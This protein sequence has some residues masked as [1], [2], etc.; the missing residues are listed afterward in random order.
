MCRELVDDPTLYGMTRPHDVL[1]VTAD[2]SWTTRELV[3]GDSI[4]EQG[5]LRFASGYVLQAIKDDKWLLIDEANRADLDRI[6]GGL[7]TW[8]SGQEVTIG[9]L[10]PTKPAEVVLGWSTSPDSSAPESLDIDDHDSDD[11]LLFT[12]GTEWRLIGTYNSVDAHRVFR[13]GLALGRRF[14]Q[15]PVPPPGVAEFRRVL[16]LSVDQTWETEERKVLLDAVSAIYAAHAQSDGAAL[17]PAPFLTIPPYVRASVD[18]PGHE[19]RELIAEAYL[20]AFGTWLARQDESFL[21]KIGSALRS[22]SVL[23]SQWDWVRMHLASLA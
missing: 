17:G 3:G 19:V 18:D 6:F 4:D 14:A 12:A 13:L 8:L 20:S 22:E 7:L 1:T 2:E 11:R 16:D 23:G 21:D 15:V 10:S 5:R 9:R